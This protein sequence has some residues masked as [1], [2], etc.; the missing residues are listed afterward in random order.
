MSSQP[1]QLKP[2]HCK[3]VMGQ[4]KIRTASQDVESK[5][6]QGAIAQ[7]HHLRQNLQPTLRQLVNDIDIIKIA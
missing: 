5:D 7:V 4:S 1:S 3:I 2:I 6:T